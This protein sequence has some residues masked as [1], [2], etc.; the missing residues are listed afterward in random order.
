MYEVA[1]PPLHSTFSILN[2]TL[3]KT[4]RTRLFLFF[5]TMKWGFCG[6]F[7]YKRCGNL[8]IFKYCKYFL[9]ILTLQRKND[10][11]V[12]FGNTLL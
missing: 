11:I 7:F 12:F 2:S 3:I 4:A 5:R 6:F 8:P 1:I 10:A 9:F